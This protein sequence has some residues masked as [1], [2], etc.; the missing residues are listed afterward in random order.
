MSWF[1]LSV[2]CLFEGFILGS[3]C[4]FVLVSGVL[5]IWFNGMVFVYRVIE[6]WVFDF[7]IIC[8]IKFCW[9]GVI[10]NDVILVV[11]GGGMWKY[12]CDKN[13]LFVEFF[14]VMV[15]VFV[16]NMCEKIDMGN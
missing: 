11:V 6:G 1:V 3:L 7:E 13:E 12:F 14:V 2:G 5:C 16:C 10:V 4:L 9:V 15:F 8:D